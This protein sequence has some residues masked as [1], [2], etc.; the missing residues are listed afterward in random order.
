MKDLQKEK[1][2]HKKK[3]RTALGRAA[4]SGMKTIIKLKKTCVFSAYSFLKT[5]VCLLLLLALLFM[6]R[7]TC[8]FQV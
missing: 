2:T 6:G 8:R 1:K 3:S 7:N 5:N 4:R